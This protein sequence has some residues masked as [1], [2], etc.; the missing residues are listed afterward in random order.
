MEQLRNAAKKVHESR[1][2]PLLVFGLLGLI[3]LSSLILNNTLILSYDTIFHF[4]RFYDTAEQIRNGS[5]NYFQMN[6]GFLQTGRIV[7]ALYGPVVAYIGGFIL[8]L[9]YNWI[10]FEIVI[11]LLVM[12]V[13]A[14]SM[15]WLCKVNGVSRDYS[16]LM[17][18]LYMIGSS[19]FVWVINQQFTGVGAAVMPVFFIGITLMLQKL[20]IPVLGVSVGMAVLI[21]THVV[22]SLIAFG[23]SLPII[24]VSLVLT[25]EKWKMIKDGLIAIVLTLALTFNVWGVMISIFRH[26]FLIPTFPETSM[27][28]FTVSL[29]GES[30]QSVVK[31]MELLIFLYVIYYVI[32]RWK[33]L[34]YVVK[35]LGSVAFG[36]LVL[37]T[38]IVPWTRLQV[39]FPKLTT[40]VQFPKRFAV[41]PFILFFLLLG[42]ILTNDKH[43]LTLKPLH[44]PSRAF[45]YA[46]LFFVFALNMEANFQAINLG[47]S[48]TIAM[49]QN[50]DSVIP[51]NHAFS[52]NK[53]YNRTYLQDLESPNKS[54]LVNDILKTTPDYLPTTQAV[55]EDNY[56]S[57]HPYLNNHRQLIKHNFKIKGGYTKKVNKD[58]SLTVTWYN[59]HSKTRR[60][61]VTVVKYSA[62]KLVLNGKK[63]KP[64]R[65]SQVGA[66][67]VKAKP[68][69]NVLT[70]S[71]RTG[72]GM[73]VIFL[74]TTL[75]WVGVFGYAIVRRFKN[76]KS[77][78]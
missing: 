45:T 3:A 46:M 21:Q 33:K 59:H 76:K 62:T 51:V 22:S 26:N 70:V 23:A 15:Y 27:Q 10:V 34:N 19:V 37:S 29:H 14:F 69:K 48:Q 65:L 28:L 38:N 1:F 68:G 64:A 5:Y 63:I 50:N 60:F 4:N 17:G 36:F 66:V 54:Y 32:T 18:S 58:G 16:I 11:S 77:N 53:K 73:D 72:L 35:T 39:E 44:Y 42:M 31:P 61:R 71:Y 13:A 52:Y 20:R 24:I 6:Y 49:K 56:A 7:N 67:T 47:V 55:N 40:L 78:Q 75:S 9:S 41:I 57:V 12:L 2:F 74:V 30:I 8:L 25:K 43:A